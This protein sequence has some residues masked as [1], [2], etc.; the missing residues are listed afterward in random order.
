MR[1][2]GRNLEFDSLFRQ[3]RARNVGVYGNRPST[4]PDTI[5]IV[6]DLGFP[7]AHFGIVG[8]QQIATQGP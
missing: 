5:E 7:D 8:S 3:I 6:G 1:R 2:N 4:H